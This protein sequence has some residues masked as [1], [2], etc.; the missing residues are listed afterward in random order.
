M[1]LGSAGAAPAA[2]ENAFGLLI[3]GEWVQ[4]SRI[5]EVRNPLGGEPVAA[6]QRAG[7]PCFGVLPRSSHAID[8]AISV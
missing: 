1:T 3:G 5:I 8:A 7:R 6:G 4:C 2:A